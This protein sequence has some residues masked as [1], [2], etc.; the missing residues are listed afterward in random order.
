MAEEVIRIVQQFDGTGTVPN[1]VNLAATTPATHLL[2]VRHRDRVGALAGVLTALRAAEINVQ[3]VENIIFSGA[4]AASARL[5]LDKAPD[6]SVMDQV[7]TSSD[8]VLAVTL[9]TL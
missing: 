7:R 8:H 4:E 3:E 9:R 6:A 2:V 5:R 1:C